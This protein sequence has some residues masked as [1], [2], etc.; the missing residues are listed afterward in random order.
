MTIA[1]RA[2]AALALAALFAASAALVPAAA[3]AAPIKISSDPYTSS[4]TG[5]H[6]SE[7]EPDSFAVGSRIVTAFQVG[8]Y[9][10]GG[11]ANVGWA[12]SADAGVH[13]RHGLMPGVT[14]AGGGTEARVTDASVAYDRKHAV[15]LVAS[16]Q[17]GPAP[18]IRGDAV[19]VNRSTDGGLTWSNPSTVAPAVGASD[20]DKSWIVCD[21]TPT[22]P[23]Y[24]NCYAQW[25]DFGDSGR[26]LMSTSTD[27]GAT[28]GPAKQTAN[29]FT[30][31]GGQPVVQPGGTVIVPIASSFEDGI[32]SFR[33]IDGGATWGPA[34]QVTAVDHHTV[35]GSVRSGPL[36]SAEIDAA[37]RVYVA[38]EDCRF[39]AAC[40]AN[41]IVISTTTD[42]VLWSKVT[43]VPLAPVGSDQEDFV[44]GLAVDPATSGASAHLALAYHYLPTTGCQFD[45]CKVHVG[46]VRSQDGGASW[47]RPID[48]T[49]GMTPVWMASTSEGYMTGDYIST[50][51]A[52]GTPH[53]VY[54]LAHCPKGGKLDEATYVSNP[55]FA[56]GGP[57]CPLPPRTIGSLAVDPYRFH[58]TA[59][60]PSIVSAG[61]TKVTYK[62]S[63]RGTTR[64]NVGHAVDQNGTRRWVRVQGRFTRD[65]TAGRNA[66]RFSGHIGGHALAPGLYRLVVQPRDPGSAPGKTSYVTFRISK[67]ARG[68]R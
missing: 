17:L 57:N 31:L 30:G 53:P 24:G 64:F 27:G 56:K 51:F 20:F 67:P 41:D 6:A 44:P 63:R 34:T 21:G 47:T 32:Y 49:G 4:T 52:A 2:A 9:Q 68:S 50:S 62:S 25:D 35:A 43:R 13:W 36:P 28:W 5:Q 42:G 38:W 16:V 61:G 1:R 46:I 7:V 15:W 59:H 14:V 12:T 29:S 48:L 18:A 37:G 11:G 58:P 66:F 23:H 22:S 65:D 45:T 33:S 40:S 8:R 54:A 39:R 60:G 26:V 3:A 19:V 55:P 10:E